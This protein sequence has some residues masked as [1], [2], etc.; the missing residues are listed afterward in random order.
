MSTYFDKILSVK[1]LNALQLIALAT[2]LSF[3]LAT[4]AWAIVG[5][6]QDCSPTCHYPSV[7]AMGVEIAPGVTSF[8]CSLSLIHK[9]DNQAIMMTNAHCAILGPVLGFTLGVSFDHDVTH[10]D[11]NRYAFA[12]QVIMHPNYLDARLSSDNNFHKTRYW[13]SALLIVDGDELAKL[14]GLWPGLVPVELPNAGFLDEKSIKR[15]AKTDG[16]VQVGYGINEVVTNGAS[17][18]KTSFIPPV[19]IRT[20][21]I[22][23]FL[24][25]N[26]AGIL[27]QSENAN[28]LDVYDGASSGDSGSPLFFGD[29]QVGIYKGG[30]F[31]VWGLG[32]RVDHIN[33]LDF[34]CMYVPST[35][36]PCSEY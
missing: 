21:G 25:A 36:Y 26:A 7:G 35:T 10:N 2:I 14:N 1:V 8:G 15:A 17:P 23:N 24:N 32:P 13:D 4:N 16:L 11:S 22:V 3:S 18:Q 33:T 29:V 12:S 28:H 5:G 31:S 27:M 6:E 20:I 30:L 19:A 9:D 34:I